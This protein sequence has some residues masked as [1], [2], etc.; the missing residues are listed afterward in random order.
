MT[1][2]LKSRFDLDD[3]NFVSTYDELPLWSAPFGLLLLDKVKLQPRM[4]V[5]DIGCGAGF[6]GIELA[7]RLGNTTTVYGIDPWRAALTKATIKARN[8][9]VQNIRLL[10][11]D[12]AAMGFSDQFFDLVVSNL[13]INNFENRETVLREAYRVLK[14]NGQLALTSNFRGHMNEFYRIF[15]ETLVALGFEELLA[16]LNAHIEHRSDLDT[17]CLRLEDVGFRVTE[18]C[19]SS[20]RL[21]FLDGSSL[22]RHYFIQ[23]GFLG[24]WKQ[25]V[26]AER[27]VTVFSE[28][29]K[30]LNVYAETQGEL[31]LSIP[32]GYVAAKR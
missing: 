28:L 2:Y 31:A 1:S 13:G 4:K 26:P 27:Q 16:P 21:R 5:L 25:I 10:E 18:K 9:G 14:V 20:F 11:G 19:T 7:Q 23:L 15:Q 12:A 8:R 30:N 32:F 29:E 3:Q 6:P 24:G 22:L 17:L